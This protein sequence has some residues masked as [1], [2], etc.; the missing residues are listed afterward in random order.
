MDTERTE[1]LSPLQADIAEI[2]HKLGTEKSELLGPIIQL[3][4]EAHAGI[5]GADGRPL[6]LHSAD[7]A[8][9]P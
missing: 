9:S 3:A 1:Q 7:V 5:T 6:A 8:L 2:K 4:A